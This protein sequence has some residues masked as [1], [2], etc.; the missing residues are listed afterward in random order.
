[1]FSEQEEFGKRPKESS[2]RSVVLGEIQ[3][4]QEIYNFEFL[5]T[6]NYTGLKMIIL[7]EVCLITSYEC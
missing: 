3:I 1:M 6:I 7:D 4:Q 5:L 2:C